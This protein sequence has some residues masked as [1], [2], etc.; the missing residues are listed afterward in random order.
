MRHLHR[1]AGRLNTLAHHQPREERVVRRDEPE[2]LRHQRVRRVRGPGGEGL[3]QR[4][5]REP[6]QLVQAREQEREAGRDAEEGEEEREAAGE[7]GAVY[8]FLLNGAAE[9]STTAC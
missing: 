6:G 3:L 9:E 8:P 1:A 7:H 2:V 5:V 4:R